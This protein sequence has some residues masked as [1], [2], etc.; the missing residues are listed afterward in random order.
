M[1]LRLYST[2]T[3]H[4]CPSSAFAAERRYRHAIMTDDEVV[5]TL[6]LEAHRCVDGAA[7][8]AVEKLGLQRRQ[9][10]PKQGEVDPEALLVYPPNNVLSPEEEQAL[11]SMKL[12]TVQRSALK[13][14]IA[15]GCAIAFFDFFNLLDAT[16]DP[17]VKPP[18]KSWLGA[19]LVAPKDHDDRDML[20]D[21]FFDSYWDYDEAMKREPTGE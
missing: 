19:W 17:E 16:A 20:H 6:L 21:A 1:S 18:T 7:E 14:L 11:R 2:T 9:P 13:K 15:D 3:P 12:S 5:R 8:A 10:T 4:V